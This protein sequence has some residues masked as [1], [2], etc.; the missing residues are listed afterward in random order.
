MVPDVHRHA[1]TISNCLPGSGCNGMGYQCPEGT[2]LDE[3]NKRCVKLQCP[4]PPCGIT[5]KYVLSIYQCGIKLFVD[6]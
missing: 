2:V 5:I 1:K 6:T 3:E 4:S